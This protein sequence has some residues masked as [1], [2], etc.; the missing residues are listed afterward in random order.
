MMII[1]VCLDIQETLYLIPD[2]HKI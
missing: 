1:L 2:V